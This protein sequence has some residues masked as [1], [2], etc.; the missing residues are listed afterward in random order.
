MNRFAVLLVV[1]LVLA[2]LGGGPASARS[3][4]S[5]PAAS[6]TKDGDRWTLE[7]TFDADAPAW[8]FVHSA[9]MRDGQPQW[10]Q[11]QWRVDTPGVYLDRLGFRD[12]LRS[13]DGGPVPRTVRLT[14]TPGHARVAASYDPA[15]V[16]SDGSIALFSGQF[17]VFPVSVIDEV[18]D[19]P[20]DL[21]GT[22]LG[23]EP[24]RVTWRDTE[25]PILFKGERREAVTEQDAQTYVLFGR[26][27]AV[28][29]EAMATV[30]DPETPQWIQYEIGSYAPTVTAYYA[31][32]FGATPS[33]RPT[34]MAAWKGPTPGM[35]SMGGSV[36]PGLIVASF[37]GADVVDPTDDLR[38]MI[39]WFIGHEAAH[40]WLGHTVRYEYARDMWITEGGADLMAIRALS[41][42]N[43]D[44]DGLAALQQ[45]VDDCVELTKDRGVVTA[46]ERNEHRAYYACGA[47]IS[48]AAEASQRRLNGGDAFD[49]LRP[50][51]VDNSD[52]VL[53]RDEWLSQLDRT[54]GDARL[55]QAVQQLLDHGSEDP[56]ATVADLFTLS[57]VGHHRMEGRVILDE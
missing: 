45:E 35:S 37:E 48:L 50:L 14:V 39:R 56:A 32:E 12:V 5:R 10:R 23:A 18:K 46:S 4:D 22:E 25:G 15:L 11:Q 53:T 40:F 44:Y 28:E 2:S 34:V 33:V 36:L 3:A 17:D 16:F 30:I 29:H 20:E 52:A 41:A 55:R 57:G 26:S 49:F 13:R 1:L 8:G 21:N 43:S 42:A 47:V 9:Q 19:M 27:S 31:A 54:S 6:L 7:F 24:T 38:T 51:I